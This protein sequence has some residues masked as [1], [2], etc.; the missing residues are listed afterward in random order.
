V[1]IDKSPAKEQI[2]N[3]EILRSVHDE[4]VLD[5]TQSLADILVKCKVT[6]DE[7]VEILKQSSSGKSVILKR[8]PCDVRV[9]NYNK[10]ISTSWWGNTDVQYVV[11]ARSAITYMMSYVLKN[12]EGMSEAMRGIAKQWGDKGVK[13]QMKEIVKTF[14]DK[15]EVGLPEAIYRIAHIPLF[16]KSR[17][18]VF[19][20]PSLEEKRDRIIKTREV[21]QQMDDNDDDVF[22]L[23][24]HDRYIA[25]P[26]N[27]EDMCLADFATQYDPIPKPSARPR[28]EVIKL[29]NGVGYMRKRYEKSFMRTHVPKRGTED[30]FQ[31]QLLLFFP[32][33]LE[34]DLLGSF[35]SYA[36]MYTEVIE[37]INTNSMK[38]NV[39]QD[40]IDEAYHQ[41]QLNESSSKRNAWDA[42]IS[43]EV[44]KRGKRNLHTDK[45]N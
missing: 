16:Y 31:A 40:E 30:F 27:L 37:T 2:R 32:Y 34:T 1:N 43:N 20:N 10:E 9:N 7:Y 15:R 22:Q 41:V 45:E 33:R 42:A 12:D 8:E 38:H 35:T 36:E 26:K 24:I 39:Y 29:L 19:T 6:E 17:N 28:N 5:S 18:V 44:K 3:R 11:D 25:R 21:L 13:H 14:N 23:A 4:V